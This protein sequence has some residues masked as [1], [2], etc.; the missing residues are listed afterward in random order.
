M[1]VGCRSAINGTHIEK[2]TNITE[3]LR[4]GCTQTTYCLDFGKV[5]QVQDGDP[6]CPLTATPESET[7]TEKPYT[8]PTRGPI[9][10]S[11]GKPL[12]TT[13]V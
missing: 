3:T 6:V 10:C 11:N 13:W 8:R 9:C 7:T 4:G 2:G 5:T 1:I 12:G